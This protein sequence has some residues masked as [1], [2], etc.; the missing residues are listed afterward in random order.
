MTLRKCSKAE[1]HLFQVVSPSF[2]HIE[3]TPIKEYYQQKIDNI[4]NG[5]DDWFYPRTDVFVHL[6]CVNCQKDVYVYINAH[7]LN[8]MLK[9]NIVKVSE[10]AVCELSP[11]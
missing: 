11:I 7:L 5:T 4:L 3:D 1:T 2:F 10:A 9:A 8:N 6:E